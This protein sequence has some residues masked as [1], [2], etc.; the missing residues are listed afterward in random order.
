[1]SDVKGVSAVMD[2]SWYKLQ[3]SK[4]HV[5]KYI[6]YMLFKG[7][8]DTILSFDPLPPSDSINIYEKPKKLQTETNS[9]TVG[10]LFRSL[11]P[12]FNIEEELQP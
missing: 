5:K 8:S 1:M 9:S 6:W 3:R 2:V 4:R 10:M 7:F 12:N 11:L